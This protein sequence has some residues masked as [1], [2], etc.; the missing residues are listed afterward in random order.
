MTTPERGILHTWFRSLGGGWGPVREAPD[1]G[2]QEWL[3]ERMH[4]ALRQ[5]GAGGGDTSRDYY[6]GLAR[7]TA[8][9]WRQSGE[10]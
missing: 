2:R 4:H 3:A 1:A 7:L 10:S 6:L 9:A 5:P 8:E